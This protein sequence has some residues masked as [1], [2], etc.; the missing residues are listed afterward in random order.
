[1]IGDAIS[2]YDAA[3]ANNINFVLRKTKLNRSLQ[4]QLGCEMI[5]DFCHG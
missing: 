1:M 3:Q 2:D 5:E 4:A